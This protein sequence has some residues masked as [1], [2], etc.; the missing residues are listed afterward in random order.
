MEEIMVVLL[1]IFLIAPVVA[2]LFTM[3][4]DI[5][6]VLPKLKELW[7]TLMDKIISKVKRL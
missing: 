7:D 4:L 5:L 2:V 1:F 3:C 6:G